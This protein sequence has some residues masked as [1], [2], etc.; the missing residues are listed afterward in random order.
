MNVHKYGWERLNVFAIVKNWMYAIFFGFRLWNILPPPMARK[1]YL[2][3]GSQRTSNDK[4]T[5]NIRRLRVS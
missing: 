1:W 5:V 4:Q 3:S 2:L